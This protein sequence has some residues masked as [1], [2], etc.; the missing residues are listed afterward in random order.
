MLYIYGVIYGICNCVFWIGNSN[1]DLR[2]GSTLLPVNFQNALRVALFFT[3]C[4]VVVSVVVI[5]IGG[6]LA[7]RGYSSV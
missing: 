5:D 3:F 1:F 7:A 4:F 2:F 6:H